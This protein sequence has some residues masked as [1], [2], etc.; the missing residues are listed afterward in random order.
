[1]FKSIT[2][3]DQG[4]DDPDEIWIDYIDDP[5]SG[6]AWVMIRWTGTT[7]EDAWINARED[8]MEELDERQ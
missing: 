5:V 1:M 3:D 6:E 4:V 2:G 7:Y 8:D